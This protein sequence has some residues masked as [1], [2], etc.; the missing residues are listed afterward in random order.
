MGGVSKAPPVK[1]D[2]SFGAPPGLGFDWKPDVT[3]FP[4]EIAQALGAKLKKAL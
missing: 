2:G 1:P 3:D 4:P